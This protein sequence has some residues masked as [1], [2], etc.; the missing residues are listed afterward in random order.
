MDENQLPLDHQFIELSAHLRMRR[1]FFKSE[2]VKVRLFSLN[3]NECIVKTDEEFS[4]GDKMVLAV[5][6][7]MEPV[8][9]EI[10][11]LVA[12]VINKTKLCSCYMYELVPEIQEKTGATSLTA[13]KIRKLNA[14]LAHRKN[15]QRK[16]KAQTTGA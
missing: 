1:S 11:E 13:E 6:Y 4:K 12:K 8:S 3:E 16:S 9:L 14:L 7:A 5:R 2:W 15:S 10:N